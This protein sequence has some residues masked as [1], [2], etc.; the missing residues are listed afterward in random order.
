[1]I[2]LLTGHRGRLGSVIGEH[3]VSVGHEVRGFDLAEG[4]DIL[5]AAAVR[6][7]VRGAAVI[8]HVAGVAGD[9]PASPD[10]IM[11]ANVLGT[12]HVL[13]A[14]EAAG[15]PRVVYLSSA[16]ALGLLERDPDY[17]PVDDDHRGLPSLPYALSKWL[18]EEMCAAFSARTNIQTLCLRPVQVFDAESYA[19]AA[20][21]TWRPSD[22]GHWHLGVHIDVRDVATAC[23][24]A[25]TC[26]APQ[27]ERLL[28][29]AADLA[30]HEPTRE[31]V[32]RYLPNVEWRGGPE[33]DHD[34]YRSLVD[35]G[36]AQRVLSWIPSHKWPARKAGPTRGSANG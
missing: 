3:L 35:F 30:A 14:A 23:A 26:T 19:A 18:A 6:Q 17:L 10:A 36:R 21:R 27:H 8:V 9:R 34:R 12:W 28:L 29:S 25:L 20:G 13:L 4:G 32:S 2:V 11:A 5:D 33:Y 15:V 24:A 7:A 16:K 1:V 31:L 22:G